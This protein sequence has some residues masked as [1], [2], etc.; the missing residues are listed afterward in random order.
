MAARCDT[1]SGELH[2]TFMDN[3]PGGSH[4]LPLIAPP[5]AQPLAQPVA[6]QWPGT[7]NTV[8]ANNLPK[9]TMTDQ[10]TT[11]VP[12]MKQPTSRLIFPHQ[13]AEKSPQNQHVLSF[14]PACE[15]PCLVWARAVG[16]LRAGVVASGRGRASGYNK[17]PKANAS[18]IAGGSDR[19]RS[20][21]LSIFSRTLY[22]LSYRAKT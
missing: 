12:T 17:I 16:V 19:R 21:D 4:A 13:Q 1:V 18:G 5:V 20:G 10:G 7:V 9:P 3:S 2:A 15:V 8:A 22:Q 6:R 14:N 11:H